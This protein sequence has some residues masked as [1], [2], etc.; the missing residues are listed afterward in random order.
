MTSSKPTPGPDPLVQDSDF[1]LILGG[2]LFQLWRRFRLSDDMLLLLRRRVL[3]ISLFCWLPLLIIAALEGRLLPG[4][5]TVPFL[6]DL[7]THIRFL[8]ATP[9]LIAAELVVHQRMLP[10]VRQFKARELVPREYLSEFDEAV[11]DSTRLRN[12]VAAELLL[13]ALV[14]GVGVLVVWRNYTA[15]DTN[16][17]YAT[18]SALSSELSLAGIWY[19]YVSLP[20]AQFLLVRWYFRLFIWARLIKR[21]SRIPLNLFATHPDGSGGLGFLAA[22][23]NAFVPL[24]IAHG[25]LLAG[26]LANRIFHLGA[27]LPQFK[28]EIVLLVVFLLAIVIGPLLVFGAQLGEARRKGRREYDALAQRYVSEFDAKWLRGTVPG[29]PLVGSADIQSLADLTGSLEVIGK[30]RVVPVSRESLVQLIGATLLPIL[31]LALTM[32]PLEELIKKLLGILF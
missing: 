11:A 6:L 20:I 22:T 8:V 12:S 10:M 1:S 29:E 30:M 31:P 26:Q 32:M 2:P 13:I 4:S 18:R 3:F 27:T 23:I 14:Y 16:T 9:L 24:A 7:E 21:V 28:P 19:G 5:A 15:L 25:A 17:W